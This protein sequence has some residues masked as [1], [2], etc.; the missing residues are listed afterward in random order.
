MNHIG[1]ART[2][3]RRTGWATFVTLVA[4][5]GMLVG[6]LAYQSLPSLSSSA[7][8]FHGSSQ[9]TT[10]F[11][12]DDPAVAN[13]DADLLAAL[14]E[15]AT[16]AADDGVTLVVISGWRSAEDQRQLLREALAK[17]GSEEEAARWVAAP[18]KSA[19]VSGEAVDIGPT[20]AAAW[21]ASHGAGYGLCQVYANEPWHYELRPRAG[22][23]GCPP[24]Y[25]DPTEDPRM[26]Q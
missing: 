5:G 25:A 18:D 1:P 7:A 20:E 9:G 8:R 10:V 14:R 21:L 6:V 24:W 15:A 26:R 4:V 23:Y 16:D 11:D 17:Y 2:P 12:D 19:H 3:A 13:L 22:A